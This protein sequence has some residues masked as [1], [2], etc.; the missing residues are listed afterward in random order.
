MATYEEGV[1]AVDRLV[2][3]HGDLVEQEA[4]QRQI[5]RATHDALVGLLDRL[6]ALAR[7]LDER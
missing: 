4:S 7:A 5:N 6:V 2:L 3:R 1:H